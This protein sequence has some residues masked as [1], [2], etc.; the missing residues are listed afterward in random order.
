M[1]CFSYL[2]KRE[3]LQQEYSQN[4]KTSLSSLPVGSKTCNGNVISELQM[5]GD[6]IPLIVLIGIGKRFNLVK[7]PLIQT[8]L[9]KENW[10]SVYSTD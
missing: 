4:P 6:S 3:V 7:L 10:I 5:R 1:Q 9:F 8:G 2:D